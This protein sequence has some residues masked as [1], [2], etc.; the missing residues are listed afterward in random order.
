MLGK[1]VSRRFFFETDLL[2]HLG[3]LRAVVRDVPIP[4]RYADEVSNL[5]IS[6][7]VGPFA[8]KHLR[9]FLQ[10]VLGQYFVRD[11]NAATLELVFGLFGVL[12]GIGYTAHYIAT[13]TPGQVASA[14]VVMAAALPVILGAQLLLQAMNFD[15]LNVPSRPIHP[16]LRAVRGLAGDEREEP[17]G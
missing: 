11:F 10:R 17:L 2:Y 5:R 8:L 12:F 13:R 9:N 4:A 3:T 16:Y 14:G 1:R 15:V 7:I 6:G